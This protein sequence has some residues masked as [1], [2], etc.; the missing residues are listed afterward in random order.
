MKTNTSV[1]IAGAGP[2]GL[3]LAL[4]LA[5]QGI[6]FV[7]LD[8]KSHISP[9]S[10]ALGIQARTLELFEDMEL[11]QPLL[12]QGQVDGTMQIIVRGKARG[13]FDFSNIGAGYSAYPYMLTLPQNQTETILYE[14][15]KALGQPL[16]WNTKLLGLEQDEQGVKAQLALPDGSTLS[17]RGDYLVGCDGARSVVRHALNCTFEGSTEGRYFYV[18]DTRVDWKETPQ[19][20]IAMCF[21]PSNFT[22]IVKMPGTDRYRFIG[23]MPKDMT[24]AQAQAIDH[25]AIERQIKETSQLDIELLDTTWHTVYKVHSRKADRFKVGR[26]FIAGDAAHVHT[27]AGGQ[28][29]NTGIQDAYN[30][31]WKL[32]FVLQGKAT[33]ALLD[34]YDSEREQNARQLLAGTDRAFQVQTSNHKLIQFIRLHVFPPLAKWLLNRKM[35]RQKL[36][37]IFSQINIQYPDSPLTQTSQAGKVHAGERL[38]YFLLEDGRKIYDLIQGMSHYHLLT[39]SL[40]EGLTLPDWVKWVPFDAFP[41]DLFGDAN[42]LLVLVRPDNYIAYVGK[43]ATALQAALD[44][45]HFKASIPA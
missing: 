34:T 9:L 31:A 44:Q 28:G 11:V 25:E 17:L 42:D 14:Q 19:T 12:E 18:M 2:T 1:I 7:L 32:A 6:D 39:S 36:F 40:P 35:L 45:D 22:A 30:L 4:A 29:M 24:D 5:Q 33:P 37:P 10:K 43:E 27:P 41:K 23:I 16:H 13:G 20:D 21:A 3:T 38:P 15:L 8:A 26:C